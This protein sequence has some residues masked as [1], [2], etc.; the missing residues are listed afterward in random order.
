VGT[1]VLLRE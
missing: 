1:E